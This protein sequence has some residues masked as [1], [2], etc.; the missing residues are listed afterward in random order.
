MLVTQLIGIA[1]VTYWRR[2][3]EFLNYRRHV[4]LACVVMMFNP[5]LPIEEG[6]S[7]RRL[8][9][10]ASMV[11]T[12]VDIGCVRSYCSPA[13]HE[14]GYAEIQYEVHCLLRVCVAITNRHCLVM[15]PSTPHSSAR[16]RAASLPLDNA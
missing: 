6:M 13:L 9:S 10:A 1:I 16:Q 14:R 7:F 3:N 5:G 15:V 11:N 12:V 4:E 2:T 8:Q